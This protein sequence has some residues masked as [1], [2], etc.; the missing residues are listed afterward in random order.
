MSKKKTTVHVEASI[1]GTLFCWPDGFD[2]AA[3]QLKS[4][5]FKNYQHAFE[6]M[7]KQ[8]DEQRVWDI[9]ICTSQFGDITELISV[10]EPETLQHAIAFLV[11]AY[12]KEKDKQTYINAAYMLESSDVVEARDY[13]LSNISDN[14]PPEKEEQSRNSK[15]KEALLSIENMDNGTELSIP[16]WNDILGGFRGSEW[17]ILGGR[18]GTGKTRQTIALLLDLA[19][20]GT[21]TLFVSV[22]MAERAIYLECISILTGIDKYK[23]MRK[24]MLTNSEI[25]QCAEAGVELSKLK[26]YIVDYIQATNKFTLM[27]R[28]IRRY[29]RDFG[30]KVFGVDYIQ[31][32]YSGIQKIDNGRILDRLTRVSNDLA[33]FVKSTGLDC[34]TPAQLGRQVETKP[35]K[36]PNSMSDLKE[37]GAFE[38]DA[39]KVV[40]LWRP[41]TCGVEEDEEGVKYQKE[42][43]EWIVTKNRRFDIITSFWT[44]RDA[45]EQKQIQQEATQFPVSSIRIEASKQNDEDVP[46]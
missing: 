4:E 36:R 26:F 8:F 11:E 21:P 46:F 3:K 15:I 16:E 33:L 40:L 10:S 41:S 43:T 7:Q 45:K 37:A 9:Q 14:P 35:G 28:V 2:I 19:K 32:M 31:I 34:L 18:P 25:K 23:M 5:M 38:Q 13:V 17:T 29:Q 22:E 39:D 20:A 12:N 6:W 27:S 44:G 24:G 30:I 1:I 42:S